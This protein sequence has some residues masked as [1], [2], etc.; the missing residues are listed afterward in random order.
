ML[1]KCALRSGGKGECVQCPKGVVCIEPI[2]WRAQ[3]PWSSLPPLDR[4]L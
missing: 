1:V 2:Q 3:A 4:L